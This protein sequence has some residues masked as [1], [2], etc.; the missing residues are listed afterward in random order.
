MEGWSSFTY[1]IYIL[2]VLGIRHISTQTPIRVLCFDMP[3][4]PRCEKHK[5]VA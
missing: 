3:H 1:S 5:K 2:P 4:K